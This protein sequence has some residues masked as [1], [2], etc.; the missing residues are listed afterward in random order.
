[1]LAGARQRAALA[2]LAAVL[3]C[4]SHV[5][6]KSLSPQLACDTLALRNFAKQGERLFAHA[7]GVTT[8]YQYNAKGEV[9]Y[10]ST[11]IDRNGT[12]DFGGTDRIRRSVKSVEA[13]NG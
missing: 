5:Q 7:G 2:R 11:D 13:L 8:L 4:A 12:I 1:A 10:T 6:L 9:E 3:P